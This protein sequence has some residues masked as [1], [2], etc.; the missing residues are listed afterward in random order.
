[1]PLPPLQPW[2]ELDSNQRRRYA[3]RFTVCSLWPLG[4]PSKTTSAQH[5]FILNT[6]AAQNHALP[7][8]PSSLHILAGG[9]TR[10]RDL[11][12]TNQLLYQLSYTGKAPKC[13]LK[14]RQ[15]NQIRAPYIDNTLPS[16]IACKNPFEILKPHPPLSPLPS[17]CADE[18]THI[19][20]SPPKPMHST[21]KQTHSSESADED[22]NASI[23][24]DQSLCLHHL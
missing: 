24:W 11:L 14:A 22:R 15:K 2:R 21:K 4:H 7:S 9:G 1:M 8:S 12:I 20:L 10:T 6:A 17:F 19:T 18:I 13:T 16:S 5:P 3:G 23:N